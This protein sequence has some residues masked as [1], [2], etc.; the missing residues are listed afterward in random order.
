MLPKQN[1]TALMDSTEE[2]EKLINQTDDVTASSLE[3]AELSRRRY[4]K[5][6][7]WREYSCPLYIHVFLFVLYISVLLLLLTVTKSNRDTHVIYCKN[8]R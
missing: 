8:L 4:L 6:N 1:Q 5:R 3:E 7:R 2:T